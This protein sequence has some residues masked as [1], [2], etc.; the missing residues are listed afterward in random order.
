MGGSHDRRRFLDRMVMNFFPE[1]ARDCSLYDQALRQRNTL[2]K[3]NQTDVVWFSA[4]EKQLAEVGHRIDFNRRKVIEILIETQRSLIK[5]GFF[6]Y[7]EVHLSPDR[8]SNPEEY[9]EE[10]VNGREKDRVAGRTL[11]GPHRSDLIV[12]HSAKNIE[13]RYCSTGEQKSLLL[14]LFVA[15]ALA[16]CN[17][18]GKSPIILL[19]EIEAH[20][21]QDNLAILFGQLQKINAQVFVTGTE[22]NSFKELGIDSLYFNLILTSE[23]VRFL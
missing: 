8:I 21:D 23:G 3:N 16:I 17:Q 14:S 10:L 12:R 7:L 1:H 22:H 13:A 20:L 11:I 19:D 6:P 5:E 9:F 18:F 15:N 4:I 2:F